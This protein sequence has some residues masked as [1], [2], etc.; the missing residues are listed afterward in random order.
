[1]CLSFYL[2]RAVAS[3]GCHGGPGVELGGA[4]HVS[5]GQAPVWGVTRVTQTLA[6]HSAIT[7]AETSIYTIREINGSKRSLRLWK[8]KK[9]KDGLTCRGEAWSMPRTSACSSWAGGRR[10][11]R[12]LWIQ[13]RTWDDKCED[14]TNLPFSLWTPLS[15]YLPLNPEKS[16]W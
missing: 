4:R 6:T 9:S 3:P 12:H 11:P 14:C 8:S 15:F 16:F 7:G 5:P 2:P 13:N 10:R 1:M